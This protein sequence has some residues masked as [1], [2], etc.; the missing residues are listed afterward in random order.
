MEKKTPTVDVEQIK[1]EF[2]VKYHRGDFYFPDK[3]KRW[4]NSEAISN[5][6]I[7]KLT[8]LLTQAEEREKKAMEEAVWKELSQYKQFVLNVLDG[9]DIADGQC[10]TKAIRFALDSR[11]IF[12]P[13]IS[14]DKTDKHE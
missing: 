3:D 2:A 13:T 11:V 12:S 8:T 7:E 5:W 10:N 6:W 9:V 14:S 1:R 4:D